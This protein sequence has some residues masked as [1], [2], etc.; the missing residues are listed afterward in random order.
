MAERC[1]EI[2]C[3]ESDLQEMI[4]RLGEQITRDYADQE[5]YVIGILK[6][7]FV[8]MADLVRAIDRPM[9][10][11]FMSVSSYGD[12]TVSSGEINIR[13]D[14]DGDI[15]GKHVLIVEDIIDTGITM[16]S[17]IRIL[18]ERE[19]LDIRVCAAFD[20]P[21]RRVVKV[22]IDYV[23]KQIPDAFI[24]GYGLDYAERY[25]NLPHVSVLEIYGG[26]Q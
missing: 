12:A 14:T 18:M 2:F 11:D 5:I 20:K 3:S 13:K 19:P 25:R 9:K 21:S 17:L 15:K 16:Q 1:T 10:I 7:S 24:V 22:N 26:D 23:G 8:F 4:R 6:G